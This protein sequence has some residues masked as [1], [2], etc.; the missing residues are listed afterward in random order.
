MSTYNPNNNMKNKSEF[1]RFLL[2]LAFLAIGSVARLLPHPSNVAPIA[3][4]AL[5]GGA[6]LTTPWAFFLPLGAMFISDLVI[7]FDLL[8][9]TL[10]VY[11]SFMVT[12]WL[13]RWL[14]SDR[15]LGRLVIASLTS[16]LLFYLVTNAAVWW[17]SGMYAHTGQGLELSYVYA[18]PFFRNTVLGDLTYTIVLLGAAEYLITSLHPKEKLA[19]GSV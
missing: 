19:H 18:L 12:V 5:L 10:A 9:I 14:R 16:S 13:G 15:T 11:G 7:G 6:M 4:M 1:S 17:F 3:A 2:I 8:P